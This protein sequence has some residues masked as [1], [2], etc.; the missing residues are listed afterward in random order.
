MFKHIQGLRI[1]QQVELLTRELIKMHS[2]S[3]TNGEIHKAEWLFKL[4]Q[5]FPY[6]QAYPDYLILQEI[7]T[8]LYKRKN[9]FALLKSP[10]NTTKTIIYFA[11]FDTVG[12]EDF[13][14]IQAIAHN[15]DA[16]ETY[17][18]TYENNV[19]V[20][21]DAQSGE[22]LFGRGSLDMQSGV[23]VHLV[24][25]LYFSEHMDELDG[26][27]LVM[28]NPDEERQHTGV[29]GA[30]SELIHLKEKYNL[31]YVAAINN[32]L[33]SPLYPEDTNKYIYTGT[34]GKLL[35]C[36]AVF[37]R[38]AHVG[39]SLTGID[40]TTIASEINLRINQNLDL[41]EKMEGELVL[42]PSCLYFRD[43]KKQ[44]DVQTALSA[45]LYFNYFY[46]EKTP[47]AVLTGLVKIAEE[48]CHEFEDRLKTSY[49]EFVQLNQLP[50]RELN[51]SVEVTT[52]ENYIDYLQKL[53]INEIDRIIDEHQ[54]TDSDAREVA[55]EIVEALQKLDP[56]K[57]PRVII[58]FA[59]PFL[60]SNY[61]KLSNERGSS[62]SEK[63]QAV[64]EK[65][66]TE[67]GETF[68][69]RKYFPYLSDG[70]F[71]SFEGSEEEI[72]SLKRNFPA[73]DMLFPIP[74]EKMKALN[75]PA[76]NVGV[77][78][79]DAHKWTER[80]YKPYSFGYLPGL[81]RAITKALLK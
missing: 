70:S 13:G 28:F 3:G 17:F 77:Y 14:A 79:K 10:N 43:D 25:L 20:M 41:V 9:V 8:D 78:G 75:I 58:F 18:S 54:N 56:E 63:I 49:S 1:E 51:W 26:N 62:L 65:E 35:P 55:F 66:A 60:P 2:Y 52:L 45:R 64:L 15:P 71:L 40:P 50:K 23:A 12:T 47:Q 74:L 72:R 24:N 67:T 53:G 19:D 39:E 80:V 34:A 37:G 29:R 38:E 31:E 6:Y 48:A 81:I 21:A 27:I 33:I 57:K 68:K 44:Y 36:F 16:L 4:F 76:F 5:S 69:L 11:H 42:P 59:P 32:D 61:L 46:Y 30:L 7:E 22:W 73:M